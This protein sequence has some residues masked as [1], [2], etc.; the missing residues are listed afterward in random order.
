VPKVS[1]NWPSWLFDLDTGDGG[2]EE[3]P[4]A[5][6]I[7]RGLPKGE[8]FFLGCSPRIGASDPTGENIDVGLFGLTTLVIDSASRP[9]G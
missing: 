9:G 6:A 7:T 1:E 5:L 2:S 8:D 4:S 3:R